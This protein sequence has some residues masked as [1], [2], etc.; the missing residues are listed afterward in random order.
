MTRQNVYNALSATYES[1]KMPIAEKK[2][3]YDATTPDM[4][5]TDSDRSVHLTYF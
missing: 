1:D 5:P 2:P 4:T 3:L